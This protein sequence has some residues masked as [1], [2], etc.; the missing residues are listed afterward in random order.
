MGSIDVSRRAL[1]KG[2]LRPEPALRPPWAVPEPLFLQLCTRCGKCQEACE[3]RIILQGAGGYPEVDFSRGECTFCQAC[4]DSCPEDALEVIGTN[5]GVVADK[6]QSPVPWN[7]IAAIGEEC[8]GFQGVYCKSCGEVCEMEAIRFAFNS[9]R[10]P[11][12][13]V[14]S[15]ACNGCGACVSVCP[16]E[17]IKVGQESVEMNV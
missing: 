8:L 6:R 5:Q 7:N 4:V 13:S 16:L 14:D 12:P 11:V 17:V 2:K 9:G 10:I 15:D 1:L 3:T